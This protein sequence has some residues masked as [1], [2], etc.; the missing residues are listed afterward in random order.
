MQFSFLLEEM[1][2]TAQILKCGALEEVSISSDKL[3]FIIRILNESYYLGLALQ[4]GG[5]TGKG[6]FLTRLAQSDLLSQI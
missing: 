3:T 5:N 6:R 4:L 2:K 1:K